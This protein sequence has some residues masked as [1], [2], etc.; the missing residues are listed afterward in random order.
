MAIIYESE[1]TRFMRE[2]MARHPEQ[3]DEQKAGLAL[4]W[5]KRPKMINELR[6]E[7]VAK[8]PVKSYHYY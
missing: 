5:N 3:H 1:Y 2:W 8:V 4:W 6:Q 7:A